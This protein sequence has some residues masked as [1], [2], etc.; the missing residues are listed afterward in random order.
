MNWLYGIAFKNK[1]IGFAVGLRETVIKTTDGG[2]TWSRQK[3]TADRKIFGFRPIYRDITFKGNTGCIVGQNGTVLISKDGGDSWYPR[4]TFF[5]P[6]IRDLLD[7]RRVQFVTPKLGYA[8]G[9]MGTRIMVTEDGGSSWTYRPVPDTEWLRAVWANPQGKVVIVGEREKVMISNDK[10]FTWKMARGEFP[11]ANVLVLLAH[12][13]DAAINLNSFYA[14]Y[15]IN[16]N[17]TIVDVGVLSDTLSSEYEETYNLEH[18]RNMWM[19]GVRTASNFNEFETGNNGSDYYH[20][21]ERLWEGEE[22]VIR[23]MVAAIRAY[24]PDIVITHGGVYGDYDK[25]GH[26]LSVRAGLVAFEA[27]GGE[28]DQFPDLTR[29]GLASWQPKKLYHLAS[30]SYPVTLDLSALANN[31]LKGT[32]GNCKDFWES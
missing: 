10:G 13:D 28:V 26:K 14:H 17:K 27:A 23:H 20:F 9:E 4:A 19:L 12:G 8:V 3:V 25:P 29:L 32:N 6:E 31:P 1:N 7:L 21:T 18:D 15:C 22:N 24:R 11:K 30:E 2:Q 5:K 16:Q